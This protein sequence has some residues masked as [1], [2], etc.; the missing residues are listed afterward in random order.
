MLY[1]GKAHWVAGLCDWAQKTMSNMLSARDLD[2]FLEAHAGVSKKRIGMRDQIRFEED[3]L[4]IARLSAANPWACARLAEESLKANRE[5][6]VCAR[7]TLSSF[8]VGGA[9]RWVCARA[10]AEDQEDFDGFKKRFV[11]ELARAQAFAAWQMD[12]EMSPSGSHPSWERISALV[13]KAEMKES[14]GCGTPGS[15][16]VRL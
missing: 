9:E 6:W 2:C 15:G 11:L 7:L 12:A 16:Q 8:S 3:G 1:P 13:E 5:V 4:G 14:C 10:G